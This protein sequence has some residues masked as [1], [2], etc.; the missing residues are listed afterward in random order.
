MRRTKATSYLTLVSQD[1]EDEEQI[2]KKKKSPITEGLGLS[3]GFHELS[4]PS[5]SVQSQRNI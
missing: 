4:F 3:R 5:S 1:K 2:E